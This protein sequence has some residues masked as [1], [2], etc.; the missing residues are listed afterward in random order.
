MNTRGPHLGPKP[1]EHEGPPIAMC[2]EKDQF[3][4]FM[5]KTQI[6]MKR[7]L[8]AF[9]EALAGPPT[10]EKKAKSDSSLESNG[11]SNSNSGSGKSGTSTSATFAISETDGETPLAVDTLKFMSWSGADRQAGDADTVQHHQCRGCTDLEVAKVPPDTDG[12]ELD[13]TLLT[14]GGVAGIMWIA[15]MSG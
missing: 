10:P 4:P 3:D 13:A 11:N 9:K 1:P 8:D 5:E 15:L 2:M 12:L 6:G 14:A 7:L